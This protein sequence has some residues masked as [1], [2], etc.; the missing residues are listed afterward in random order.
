MDA[1]IYLTLGVVSTFLMGVW[2]LQ[3]VARRYH[4]LKKAVTLIEEGRVDEAIRI[5]LS[6]HHPLCIEDARKELVAAARPPTLHLGLV[7]M[8]IVV[9]PI[10]FMVVVGVVCFE[11]VEALGQALERALQRAVSIIWK[12][13]L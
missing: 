1:V 5:P 13:F 9:W 12:T 7:V 3:R 10:P 8:C 2:Y 6:T 4:A 11:A